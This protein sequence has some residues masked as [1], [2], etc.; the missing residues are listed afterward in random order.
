[1]AVD[2]GA[3]DAVPQLGVQGVGEVDRSG[4]RAQLDHRGLRREDEDA[5][6]LLIRLGRSWRGLE[7]VA[8]PGQELTQHGLAGLGHALVAGLAQ[9]GVALGA[10]LLVGPVR[11]HAMLGVL[12]HGAGADL[13]LHGLALRRTLGGG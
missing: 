12:V 3:A 13:H 8:L 6:Q 7:Q 11:G 2:L 10:G 5:R 4:A 9:P 1:M